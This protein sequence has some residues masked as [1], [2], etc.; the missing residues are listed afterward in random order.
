MD[1]VV[2]IAEIVRYVKTEMVPLLDEQFDV[3][4]TIG[5][6]AHEDVMIAADQLIRED[7]LNVQIEDHEVDGRWEIVI[8][9]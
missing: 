2:D 6:F 7:H 1:A 8:T 4:R 5:G 9:K 3:R